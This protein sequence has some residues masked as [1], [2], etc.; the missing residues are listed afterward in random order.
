M[1]KADQLL[2]VC[3]NAVKAG[4]GIHSAAELAFMLNATHYIK[5]CLVK[6]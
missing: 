4:G 1:K 3:A 6:K 2:F 5:I